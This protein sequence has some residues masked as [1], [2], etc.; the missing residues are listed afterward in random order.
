[1]KRF[2]A[3]LFLLLG[4]GSAW[5]QPCNY[6]ASPHGRGDGL[7]E[8]SPFKIAD[9]WAVARPGTTLCLIDGAYRKADSMIVPFPGLSGTKGHPITIRALNDG[10][11][12]IDGQFVHTPIR[13]RQNAWFVI[14]GVNAQS[15]K[16][17]VVWLARGSD[18]NVFRRLVAWDA[19]INENNSVIGVH[20]SVGNLFEDVAA[21]GTARKVFSNSQRGDNV[22][23][24]RCWFRWEGSIFGASV[25]VTMLYNST[26][27][28]F[29]DM[30][31]TWSG[32]SMPQ[33]YMNV[34]PAVHMTNFEPHGPAGIL[35][36]DRIDAV[37]PK[38]A[39]IHLRGS[40]IY[41]KATDR[42]PTTVVGGGAA[43]AVFP[44][45]W[46]FGASSITLQHV[47]SV[48]A[49]AHP[50][51]DDLFGFSLTRK[52]QNCAVRRAQCEDPVIN[53]TATNITSIRGHGDVFH[54][55]WKIMKKSVGRSHTEVESPWTATDAGANLCYRWGTTTPLWPW[56]MNERIKAAT[57]A[58]GSY[59]GPCPG[60]VGGRAA[61]TRTDVSADIEQLLGTIP[62][63][64]KSS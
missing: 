9:F 29:E 11:V 17:L 27:G 37:P 7:A 54:E 15:G 42:I 1:M 44:R 60:C 34:A 13:L 2:V 6:Y 26:G 64:C 56:P 25:G 53:N 50:R 18:N 14:E 46:V 31:V 36:V 32:E 51:F 22:T 30:L 4:A 12:T 39:N 33:T 3:F 23:C 49:P 61:R 58:A 8:A 63:H 40:I 38:H 55:D 5:A 43:G 47:V 48:M 59:T 20:G 21:F 24:R 52:P 41:T 28:I 16:P 10:A 45:F 62:K 19:T 57:E 35:G